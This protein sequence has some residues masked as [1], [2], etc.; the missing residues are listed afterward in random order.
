MTFLQPR[1]IGLSGKAR[2]GKDTVGDMIVAYLKE[3]NIP[4]TPIRVNFADALYEEVAVG[5]WPATTFCYPAIQEKVAYIKAHKDNFRLILQG[6]GTDYRRKLFAE[7]YWIRK[8]KFKVQFHQL[9]KEP[10][11]I[12][13][14]DCRFLNELKTL[15]DMGANVWRI[16]RTV[17]ADQHQS[18][19]ELDTNTTFQHSID[20]NGTLQELNEKVLELLKYVK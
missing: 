19:T 14:S 12:L 9:A 13:C 17:I 3:R 20:N 1:I 8:W 18:E 5:L 4:L 11:L 10:V 16:N 6:W 2:T 7:D 15:C